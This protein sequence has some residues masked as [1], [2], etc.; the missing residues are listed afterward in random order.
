MRAPLP[1][2]TPRVTIPIDYFIVKFKDGTL[3]TVNV[4]DGDGYFREEELIGEAKSLTTYQCFIATKE[5]P[6]GNKTVHD[7]TTESTVG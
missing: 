4:D 6:R 3:R 1:K 7:S 5:K 2:V